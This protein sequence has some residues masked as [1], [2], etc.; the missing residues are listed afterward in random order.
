MMHMSTSCIYHERRYNAYNNDT[1]V[2]CISMMHVY[3]IHVSMM[4]VPMMHMYKMH[5]YI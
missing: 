3:L 5:L 2:Y 4:H 1:H